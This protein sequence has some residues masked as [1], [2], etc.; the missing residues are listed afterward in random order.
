MTKQKMKE[1]EEEEVYDTVE[2]EEPKKLKP[3]E[4]N[5]LYQDPKF[6]E[7]LGEYYDVYM[8]Y[9]TVTKRLNEEFKSKVTSETVRNIYRKNM[10]EKITNEEE[11]GKFFENS[12]IRMQKRYEESWEMIGDLVLQYKK[13]RKLMSDK[14]E[15][16]QALT[17]MKMTSQIIGITT[18]IRKQLEFIGKQQEEIRVYQQN[19]LIISP[20]QVNQQIKTYFTKMS[21]NDIQNFF[22]NLKDERFA[23]FTKQLNSEDKIEN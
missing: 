23:K 17:F 6:I 19:N 2:P 15:L 7:K 10:A 3:F 16:T 11:A 1:K 9:N 13:F 12:F 20:I 14:D 22:A 5:P 18:E 21:N 4:P 8:N